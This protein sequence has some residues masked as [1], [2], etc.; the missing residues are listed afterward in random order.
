MKKSPKHGFTLIEILVVIAIIG[1]L[2]ALLVPVIGTA[3][4]KVQI[5]TM[6]SKYSGWVSAIEQYKSVYD[7]YPILRKGA[8]VGDDEHYNLGE[9][10]TGLNFV[11]ALSGRDPETGEKLTKEDQR[12][13]NRRGRSFCE[14]SPEDFTQ[15]DGTVDYTTLADVF[16]NTKI[17]VVMDTD[18]NKH[19]IIPSEYMPDDATDAETDSKGLM[20][21]VIIFTSKKDGDEYEDVYSWR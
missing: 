20:K 16:G 11:K 19:I 18:D 8:T 6:R 13:F 9:G 15:E 2:A 7:Y 10:D 21:K 1:L 12:N 4:Q 17:H 3:M 14:F 5:T